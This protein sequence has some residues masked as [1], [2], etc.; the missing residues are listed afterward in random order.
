MYN[1][2]LKKKL[3]K[4]N[5]NFDISSDQPKEIENELV[6]TYLKKL[7]QIIERSIMPM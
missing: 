1:G 3:R 2:V 4:I 5:I 7:N 6:F